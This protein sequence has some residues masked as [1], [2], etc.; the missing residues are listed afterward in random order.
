MGVLGEV[1]EVGFLHVAVAAVEGAAAK[2]PSLF[3]RGMGVLDEEGEVGF[4]HVGP[5]AVEGAAAALGLCCRSGVATERCVSLAPLPAFAAEGCLWDLTCRMS[6]STFFADEDR[7]AAVWLWGRLTRPG[8]LP[9]RGPRAVSGCWLATDRSAVVGSDVGHT[10]A[11]C[12]GA[13]EG[14]NSQ[15][16]TDGN[17]PQGVA[18]AAFAPF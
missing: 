13:G 5:A 9:T 4:L 14:T 7:N 12:D 17:K 8:G 15:L 18:A 16:P 11:G 2:A 1:G 3:L 6:V 10:T